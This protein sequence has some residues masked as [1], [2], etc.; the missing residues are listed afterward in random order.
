LIAF[1]F[2]TSFS[3]IRSEKTTLNLKGQTCF[4]L[5]HILEIARLFKTHLCFQLKNTRD[6]NSILQRSAVRLF[7]GLTNSNVEAMRRSQPNA[8]VSTSDPVATN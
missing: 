2:R 1:L 5:E 8:L 7:L 4:M 6:Q 3:D